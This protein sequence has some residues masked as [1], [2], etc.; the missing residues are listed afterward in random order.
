MLL[1]NVC[2]SASLLALN[3]GLGI[4][5]EELQSQVN[6]RILQGKRPDIYIFVPVIIID[7][8]NEDLLLIAKYPEQIQ[9]WGFRILQPSHGK[10]CLQAAPVLYDE[11]FGIKDL[12]EFLR[13]V[14]RY[15]GRASVHPPRL[16]KL[17]CS[18]ACRSAIMFGEKLDR[19]QC[20]RL[21]DSLSKCQLPF[22]CAHGRPS[23]VP[24]GIINDQT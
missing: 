7:W 20:Q 21:L 24:L 16:F 6:N 1:T 10:Y 15:T 14:D 22:Q 2:V 4:R 23:V 11:T 18:K 13:E 19:V 12:L 9:M 17:L 5:L 3:A 8:Q